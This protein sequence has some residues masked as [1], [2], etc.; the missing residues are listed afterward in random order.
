[1]EITKE[2][3]SYNERRYGKPW[4]ALVDYSASRK[5]EFKFGEWVGKIG[6]SGELYI[7][8]EVND[9]VATGQKDFRKPRNSAPDYYI[10]TADGLKYIGDNPV[11][12]RKAQEA[13][14]AISNQDVDTDE[15]CE[16]TPP[17]SQI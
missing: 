17:N 3:G 8:A 1:M 14:K 7:N 16:I 15:G 10:V 13:A 4:I 2:T 9:I 11:E 6:G 5:G 12:A